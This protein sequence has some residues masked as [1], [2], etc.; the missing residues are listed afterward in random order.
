[1]ASS[2]FFTYMLYCYT[3]G[4]FFFVIMQKHLIK[5]FQVS[6]LYHIN[7]QMNRNLVGSTYERFCIKFPQ[8]RMK[9][10]RHRLSEPTEP[11]VYFFLYTCYIVILLGFF[12][13]AIMQKH[14]IKHFQVSGPYHINSSIC[15]GSSQ[16]IC[17]GHI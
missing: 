16:P 14:L 6:S 4:F 1:M 12:F 3:V 8:G 17:H 7:S 13:F 10:E 5:H 2:F 15:L 9:G 11:L